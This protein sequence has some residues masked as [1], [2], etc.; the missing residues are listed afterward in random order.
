MPGGR[1]RRLRW[2]KD[3]P[4]AEYPVT[5]AEAALKIVSQ[6][7]L[8]GVFDGPVIRYLAVLERHDIAVAEHPRLIRHP[9]GREDADLGGDVPERCRQDP[10]VKALID[11]DRALL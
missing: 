8:D 5:G 11:E 3:Q 2:P 9:L 10:M 1:E 4:W 6:Q 7:D